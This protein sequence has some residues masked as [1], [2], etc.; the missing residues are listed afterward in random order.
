LAPELIVMAPRCAMAIYAHPDDADVSCG[1]TLASWARAGTEVHVVVCTDGDKGTTDPQVDSEELAGLRADEADRAG[2]ALGV[3]DR[4][5]LGYSDGELP[6]DDRLRRDLVALVRGIRPEVVL[7][8]DPTAVFFGETYFNHRDHRMVGLDALDALSPAAALP[9]YFPEAGAVHQV[10]TVLLS[11]T[12]EPTVWVDITSTIEDKVTAVSC[13]RS[14]FAEGG[15]W[16]RDA[17]RLRA[18]E[19]GMRAGV[20]YAEGFR[21]LRL[22]P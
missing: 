15:Q 5:Q 11:G 16:A 8:P 12:L 4:H 21:R 2:E 1:G 17:V 22:G 10:D 18:K 20:A 13:H 9:H 14:Q 3:A 7:C 19:D 6:Q